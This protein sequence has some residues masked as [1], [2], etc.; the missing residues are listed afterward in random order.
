MLFVAVKARPEDWQPYGP[1]DDRTM[2]CMCKDPHN[3]HHHVSAT[4]PQW[5]GLGQMHVF[6]S[7]TVCRAFPDAFVQRCFVFEPSDQQVTSPHARKDQLVMFPP[8]TSGE[9]LLHLLVEQFY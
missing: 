3:L 6:N 8:V 7:G 2:T 4:A 5:K 1:N 9:P